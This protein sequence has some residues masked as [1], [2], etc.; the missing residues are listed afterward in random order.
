MAKEIQKYVFLDIDSIL[1]TGRSDHLDPARY[2]HHFDNGAVLNLRRIVDCTG[3]VI[4]ISSS[5]RHMGTSK[6]QALW[7]KWNLPGEIV[8][9]TPGCWGDLRT[10]NSRGEE[11]QHWLKH[12]AM[13][14]GNTNFRYVII[15]DF[16]KSEAIE[17]QK[18]KWISAN[19]HFGLS[20]INAIEAINIL[21]DMAPI[22][23]AIAGELVQES[24]RH[25]IADCITDG[26]T[27]YK[28]QGR[29][30]IVLSIS[31]EGSAYDISERMIAA[32]D[33][34]GYDG[35][36]VFFAVELEN[37]DSLIPDYG[38]ISQGL[39]DRFKVIAEIAGHD[40]I[41]YDEYDYTKYP[42]YTKVIVGIV[43]PRR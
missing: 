34:L 18:D 40:D 36:E 9:C 12:N 13:K 31:P 33:S 23:M 6:L 28:S 16:D 11:I 42:F 32:I 3:A 7:Q 24:V 19:P 21:N 39:N 37:K 22:P 4:V 25:K 43:L 26:Y 35:E 30:A 17:G 20:S 41:E 29:K 5:W 38:A 2:G 1:N 27:D 10:F 15:N 14:F 8:G